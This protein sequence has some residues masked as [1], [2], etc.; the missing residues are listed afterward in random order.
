MLTLFTT[1]RGLRS[2]LE[3]ILLDI[4]YDVPSDKTISKVVINGDVILG[5]TAP[6]LM[7]ENTDVAK[8]L[9]EE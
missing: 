2:I 6:V 5:K 4:M 8:V 3:N 1:S 9:P 7:H